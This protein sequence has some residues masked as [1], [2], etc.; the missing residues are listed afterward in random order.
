MLVVSAE[1]SEPLLEFTRWFASNIKLS[2][3]YTIY[4]GLGIGYASVVEDQPTKWVLYGEGRCCQHWHLIP[5]WSAEYPL[6]DFTVYD[7]QGIDHF[8]DAPEVSSCDGV[9]FQR[10]YCNWCCTMS[11]LSNGVEYHVQEIYLDN[12]RPYLFPLLG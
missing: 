12:H 11:K 5:K 8:E 7:D 3:G 9:M 6:L 2:D 10:I 4:N 1:H